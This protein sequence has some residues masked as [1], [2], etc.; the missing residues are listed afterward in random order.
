M[1]PM[2]YAWYYHGVVE[3]GGKLYVVRGSYYNGALSSVE[4]Y[5]LG[6]TTTGKSRGLSRVS[7]KPDRMTPLNKGREGGSTT[8]SDES[9]D[10]DNSSLK[11]RR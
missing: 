10:S 1:A 8:T 4:S 9:D 6:T 11:N 7:K 2:P 5:N 3:H